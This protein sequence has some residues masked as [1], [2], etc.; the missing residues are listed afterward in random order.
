MVGRF[1]V[2]RLI[3]YF[4][5]RSHFRPDALFHHELQSNG[6][7]ARPELAFIRKILDIESGK[8][9]VRQYLPAE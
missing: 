6:L 8:R 2:K 9:Y 3:E 5:R 7:W 1:A 4:C